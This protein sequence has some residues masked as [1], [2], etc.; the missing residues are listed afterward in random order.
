VVIN[1]LDVARDILDNRSA[2]YSDR[3]YFVMGGEL[4]G[5]NRTTVLTPYGP[6]LK[7]HRSLFARGISGKGSVEKY[8]SLME[9]AAQSFAYGL[10][11]D[12]Y[13]LVGRIHL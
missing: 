9:E 10:A 11:S 1:S 5:W 13:D 2:I 3:P 6:R 8:R 7:E 4:C 12:S